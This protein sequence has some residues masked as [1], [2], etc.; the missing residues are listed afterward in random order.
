[1]K[2][3]ILVL[4]LAGIFV[5]CSK[6][7]KQLSV[8]QDVVNIHYDEDYQ[9]SLNIDGANVDWNNV[10]STVADAEVGEINNSGLFTAKRIGTTKI[11][12]RVGGSTVSTEVK[13]LPYQTLF[14]EPI[15][16]WGA[17]MSSI[18]SEEKRV[19]EES[20]S[21]A[22]LFKGENSNIRNVLYVFSGD[23]LNGSIVL[24]AN[25]PSLVEKVG[26]F[27][28]ERYEYVG[29]DDGVMYFRNKSAVVGLGYNSSLG[30]NATYL[31][32]KSSNSASAILK[33][34]RGDFKADL[35]AIMR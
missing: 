19:F 17:S 18:R 32:P 29:A 34:K 24:V 14:E 25:V 2:K 30:F 35:Q 12:F 16:K 13:V 8:N 7:E 27:Y 23:K 11:T 3:V 28:Q 4:L 6:D 1:M 5:G 26:V 21:T 22:I 31:D 10:Q 20:T 33:A 9:F 15:L